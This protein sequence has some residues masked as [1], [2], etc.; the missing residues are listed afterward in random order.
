M[1]YFRYFECTSSYAIIVKNYFM[2][3][4]C[5]PFFVQFHT[6]Y[7]TGECAENWDNKLKSSLVTGTT[8]Y[9]MTCQGYAYG[10]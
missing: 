3:L 2:N 7:F 9:D 6:F 4:L 5:R 8:L 1:I 10:E